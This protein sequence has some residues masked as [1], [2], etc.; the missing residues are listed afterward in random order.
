[1]GEAYFK[2]TIEVVPVVQSQEAMS[3]ARML[4]NSEMN[5]YFDKSNSRVDFKLGEVSTST[6]IINKQLD[7]T[8]SYSNGSMGKVAT[9]SKP[10]ELVPS[11]KAKAVMRT[12][13]KAH[14][15]YRTILGFK[16]RKYTLND[17]QF[18][19]TYWCTDEI[20]IDKSL[21]STF[22]KDLPSFPLAFSTINQGLKMM[23]QASDYSFYLEDKETLFSTNVPVGYTLM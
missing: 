10:D 22:N 23:Y 16:C 21:N 1:V 13:V 2:Y 15:E 11:D 9:K 5:I 14:D 3:T 17:G 4:R 18:E 20:K 6:T 12:A 8:I 7:E 19:A